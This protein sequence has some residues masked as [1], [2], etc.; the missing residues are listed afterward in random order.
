MIHKSVLKITGCLVGICLLARLRFKI[1]S[2][3]GQ[4]CKHDFFGWLGEVGMD[5]NAYYTQENHGTYQYYNLG[6][7]VLDDGG[8]INNCQLPIG[9]CYLW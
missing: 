6:D 3:A 8:T 5:A 2:V 4:L 7:Y 1:I 9:V